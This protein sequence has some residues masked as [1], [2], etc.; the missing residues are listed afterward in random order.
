MVEDT[1][2]EIPGT[3]DKYIKQDNLPQMSAL[4]ACFR[5]KPLV[6]G[7]TS[8]SLDNKLIFGISQPGMSVYT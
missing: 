5:Y 2:Y 4:T 8:S 7:D 3:A 6:A 1:W